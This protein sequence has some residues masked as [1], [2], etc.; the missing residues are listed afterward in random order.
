MLLFVAVLRL[1]IHS[2]RINS[3]TC[4]AIGSL[5][6]RVGG[7][8]KVVSDYVA[9]AKFL[10]SKGAKINFL[11]KYVVFVVQKWRLT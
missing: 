11:D 3:L 7:D 9:V 2:C 1:L 4:V 5:T 6:E 10:V 8:P